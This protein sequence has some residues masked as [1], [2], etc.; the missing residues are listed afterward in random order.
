MGT[1]KLPRG[2]R[3]L[4]SGRIQVRYMHDGR[5][6][7]SPQTYRT[8]ADAR[9]WLDASRTDARQGRLVDGG[10][11][12]T[13]EQYATTWVAERPG[14]A[15]RTREEYAGLLKRHLAPTFGPQRLAAVQAAQVRTWYGQLHQ[16]RPSTAAK[17]YRLLRAIYTTAVTDHLAPS[18]PCQVRGA[19]QEHAAERSTATVAEVE[20]MTAAM[21]PRLAIAVTL[22]AWCG[23]RIGEVRGLRRQDVDLDSRTVTVRQ[24]LGELEDGS[25]VIGGPKADSRRTVALPEHVADALADHL[26]RF[27]APEPGALVVTGQKGGPLRKCV[28]YPAFSTARAAAGRPDLTFHTLRHTAN[29]WAAAAGIS[30]RELMAFLGHRSTTVALRYQHATPDRARVIADAMDAL[31]PGE[32]KRNAELPGT[33]LARRRLGPGQTA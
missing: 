31:F 12:L 1:Q 4:P 17:A 22:A 32:T 28:L 9:A 6:V 7:T 11:R 29:T 27:T 20:A 24:A 16:Q 10:S 5:Q 26:E 2:M 13:F 19:G 3:R 14:L 30:T 25:I 33:N 8:I 23:L 18:Q 15:P 21:P